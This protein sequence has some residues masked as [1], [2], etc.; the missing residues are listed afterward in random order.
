MVNKI[1]NKN[2]SRNFRMSMNLMYLASLFIWDIVKNLINNALHCI[3]NNISDEVQFFQHSEWPKFIYFY[4]H[5]KRIRSSA[6]Y[7]YPSPFLFTLSND[8]S[9]VLDFDA[10]SMNILSELS[11]TIV[12][13]HL[14]VEGQKC[15]NW[16]LMIFV[17]TS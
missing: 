16:I 6:C 3:W 7:N 13:H 17:L 5:C 14:T 2:C 11:I 12:R 8:L 15:L 4:N 10:R 1:L 9:L